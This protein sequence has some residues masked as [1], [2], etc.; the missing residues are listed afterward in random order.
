MIQ[1]DKGTAP[2][3]LLSDKV[4]FAVDRL[5]DFYSSSRAQKRYSF[6]FNRDFD[7]EIK[8]LKDN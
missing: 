6:P 2:Q 7:R 4:M 3:Y 1:I 8:R 5:K